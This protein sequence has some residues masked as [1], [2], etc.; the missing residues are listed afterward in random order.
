VQGM[1]L[2]HTGNASG[3][4]TVSIGCASVMPQNGG[5][6]LGLINCADEA[7]YKAKAGGRNRVEAFPGVATANT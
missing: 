2:E 6:A 1:A 4:V 7:L 5:T 3:V